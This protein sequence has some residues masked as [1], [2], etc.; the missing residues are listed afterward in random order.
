MR[1]GITESFLTGSDENLS[2]LTFTGASVRNKKAYSVLDKLVKEAKLEHYVAGTE[3]EYRLE[4]S[5]VR[6]VQD[7]NQNIGGLQSAATL[8]FQLLK[9]SQLHETAPRGSKSTAQEEDPIISPD[10]WSAFEDAGSLASIDQLEDEPI[11]E[12]SLDVPALNVD[13]EDGIDQP[14]QS[15]QRMFEV[16]INHLG[17]SLVKK[18]NLVHFLKSTR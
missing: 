15:P 1:A 12:Q 17:P 14:V 4:K 16:F 7:I 10:G 6:I 13:Q 5:L 18:R 3:R 2:A 9:Q 11:E 8:Q